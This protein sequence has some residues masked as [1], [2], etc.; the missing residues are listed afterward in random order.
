VLGTFNDLSEISRIV[1]LYGAQLLVDAAQLVA[2]RKVDVDKC[3]IDYLVFSAHKVYA[4]FGTGV[5]IARKGLL[6]F[7]SSEFKK[8]QS[9]GEENVSGIAALG[10][11]LLLLQRIGFDLIKKE[12]QN[13]TGRL[14]RGLAQI[15][16]IKIYGIKDQDSPSFDQKGGVIAFDLKSSMANI[17]AK[18]LAVRGGIGIRYGCH[19][20]HM[21]IKYLLKIPPLLA[22]I[23]HL[24]LFLFPQLKLPGI[25]RIS[26]GIGNSGNDVDTLISV[27]KKIASRPGNRGDRQF[28][29]ETPGLLKT[30]IK[31]QIKNFVIAAEREVYTKL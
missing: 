12:E 1:H 2:H 17:V 3:A 26:L 19:C 22:K 21:L 7:S 5:L 14:L 4:P 13:L 8:I 16:G 31:K 18:E 28:S 27:L 29:S 24:I 25:A 15:Q 11:A 10:K 20:A 6:T 30:D 23:Q 9:S